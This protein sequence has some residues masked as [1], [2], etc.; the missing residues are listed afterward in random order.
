MLLM[1]WKMLL[2][3]LP[4]HRELGL[5]LAIPTAMLL[6]LLSNSPEGPQLLLFTLPAEEITA[7]PPLTTISPAAT[8]PKTTNGNRME[9]A[10]R[11]RRR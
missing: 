2:F 7:I 8:L 4:L 9:V 6:R 5:M 11:R 1:A 10:R 3:L